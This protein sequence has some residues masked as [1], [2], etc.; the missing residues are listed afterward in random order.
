FTYVVEKDI[1]PAKVGLRLWLGLSKSQYYDWE[2]KPQ[3]YGY[4]SNLIQMANDFMEMQYISQIESYPTGNIFLLKSSH[5]HVDKQEV[6]ITNVAEVDR[7][8]ILD[9]VTKLGL[10]EGT[11]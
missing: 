11:D 5:Q 10:N 6:N 3:V 9:T 4:K 7:N 1:K 8:N 2:T